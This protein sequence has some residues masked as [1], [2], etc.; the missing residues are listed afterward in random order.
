NGEMPRA[1]QEVLRAAGAW[2]KVNGDAVYGTWATPFGEELGEPT[3]KGT[4]DV[5]GQ[6]LFLSRTEYRVTAKPGKLYFT[7][8][9]G[10]RVPFVLPRMQNTV[11]RAYR[12]A[13]HAPVEVRDV[14]GE[15]QLLFNNNMMTDPMAT[16]VVV[17][18][19]GDRARPIAASTTPSSLTGNWAVDN[20]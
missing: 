5:R 11:T 14:N 7:F 15:K 20:S 12:L 3:A 10:P 2:L 9:A 19:D 18:I 13:D 16:V 1:A 17:E 4:K 8:F 6:P